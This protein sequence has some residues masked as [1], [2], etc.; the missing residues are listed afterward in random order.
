VRIGLYGFT[1]NYDYDLSVFKGTKTEV[2]GAYIWDEAIST[3]DNPNVTGQWANTDKKKLA[4]NFQTRENF[5][6]MIDWAEENKIPTRIAFNVIKNLDEVEK[7]IETIRGVLAKMNLKYCFL[8]DFN[9]KQRRRNHHCYMHLVKPFLY[10]DGM[11]YVCPCAEMSVE[12]RFKVNDQFKV[13]DIDG[14][15]EYYSRPPSMRLHGCKYCKYAYQNE[16][17]DDIMTPTT[18][19]EFV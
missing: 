1:E 15:E 7:N 13:C 2:S 4:T 12:N 11:V 9:F 14:I 3:S 5:L 6:R 16:L 17:V 10:T 18:H 19:N 8:S